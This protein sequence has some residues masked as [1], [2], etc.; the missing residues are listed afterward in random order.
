ML[1]PKLSTVSNIVPPHSEA[2]QWGDN[3]RA[4][5]RR[6]AAPRPMDGDLEKLRRLDE[7]LAA[8]VNFSIRK[9]DSIMKELRNKV[10][11][12]DRKTAQVQAENKALQAKKAGLE[13][14]VDEKLKREVEE[15]RL[16]E[17]DLDIANRLRRLRQ[18]RTEAQQENS[19]REAELQEWRRERGS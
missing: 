10:A 15:R 8:I 7:D 9:F 19:R 14:Q 3:V 4:V 12:V 6:L 18:I 11:E 17:Q 5:Y 2:H 13:K 16:S 1:T